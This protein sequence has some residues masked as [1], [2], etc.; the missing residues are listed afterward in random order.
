MSAAGGGAGHRKTSESTDTFWETT[1][2]KVEHFNDPKTTG[3]IDFVTT[4]YPDQEL[5]I[6]LEPGL[7]P[8]TFFSA[9]FR[10]EDIELMKQCGI[11]WVIGVCTIGKTAT[12]PNPLYWYRDEIH[13]ILG[14]QPEIAHLSQLLDREVK[15]KLWNGCL[16][17]FEKWYVNQRYIYRQQILWNDIKTDLECARTVFNE[18]KECDEMHFQ[19]FIRYLAGYLGEKNKNI[20]GD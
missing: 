1:M 10:Q 6:Y 9:S 14:F 19:F 8:G 7:R 11:N 16:A 2:N 4:G 13:K 15:K 3:K 18:F 5:E 12:G 20:E 17:F